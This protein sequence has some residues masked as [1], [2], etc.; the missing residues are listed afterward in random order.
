MNYHGRFPVDLKNAFA[1]M[2]GCDNIRDKDKLREV[3]AL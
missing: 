2:E 1:F 3:L